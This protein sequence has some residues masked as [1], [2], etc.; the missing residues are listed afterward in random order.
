MRLNKLFAML[1]VLAL[2]LPAG[3]LAATVKNISGDPYSYD[4]ANGTYRLGNGEYEAELVDSNEADR[5]LSLVVDGAATLYL[6]ENTQ[7]SAL[8]FV[9]DNENADSLKLV[10]TGSKNEVLSIGY[11]DP[12]QTG[13]NGAG[14]K[15]EIAGDGKNSTG[16]K[17]TSGQMGIRAADLKISNILLNITGEQRVRPMQA[18]Q[19]KNVEIVDSELNMEVH[20]NASEQGGLGVSGKITAEDSRI[21]IGTR[22]AAANGKLGRGV[23]AGEGV[24]LDDSELIMQGEQ[25]YAILTGGAVELNGNSLV[26]ASGVEVCCVAVDDDVTGTAVKVADTSAVGIEG[27]K[28]GIDTA[29]TV[30]IATSTGFIVEGQECAI[31]GTVKR[32]S[33]VKTYHKNYAEDAWVEFTENSTSKQCVSM[34]PV[35]EVIYEEDGL[36]SVPVDMPA[37]MLNVESY[38]E[39][40]VELHVEKI[41]ENVS[42]TECFITYEA[43]LYTFDGEK[44]G[45]KEPSKMI[46]PY[47]AGYTKADTHINYTIIHNKGTANEE[48]FSTADGS[49][50]RED[51]GLVIVVNSLSPF[52]LSWGENVK[53]NLPQTGDHSSILLWTALLLI[54][55]AVGALLFRK[56]ANEA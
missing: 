44:I 10:F 27:G 45:L 1:L 32:G 11:P 31:V 42:G 38:G 26:Y 33:G 17:V 25:M 37:V 22:P 24:T 6:K 7:M 39:E 36:P 56:K 14:C 41:G 47:P 8:S 20:T 50:K 16:L 30:E 55:G 12:P 23:Y 51:C 28:I 49:I 34:V 13:V 52:E 19:C 5:V 48:H 18:I 3:A 35:A 2:L 21:V 40:G 53:P 9:G 43:G 29:G 54:S 46:F 15:L 4:D